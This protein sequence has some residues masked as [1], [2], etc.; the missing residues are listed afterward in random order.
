MNSERIYFYLFFAFYIMKAKYQVLF[1]VYVALSWLLI[2]YPK[3]K[4]GLRLTCPFSQI[5]ERVEI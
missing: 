1:L 3:S 2:R 4:I 5:E